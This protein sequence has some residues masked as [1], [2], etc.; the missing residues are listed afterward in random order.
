MWPKGLKIRK[1]GSN[2]FLPE[3]LVL[4]LSFLNFILCIWWAI[5]YSGLEVLHFSFSKALIAY[6]FWKKKEK[7]NKENS[8]LLPF[9]NHEFL[10]TWTKCNV[11]VV[12][13]MADARKSNLV[14][15]MEKI[16]EL[17][18]QSQKKTQKTKPKQ[19][20]K[21][22]KEKKRRKKTQINKKPKMS[23]FPVSSKKKKKMFSI[24]FKMLC[25][26]A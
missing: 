10:C 20:H 6:L 9:K 17:D 7:K 13:L 23:S 25:C 8:F 4:V 26:W 16:Q 11:Q 2:T 14:L 22:E 21:K 3:N 15:R 12:R 24:L 18:F 1:K 5:S 19:T